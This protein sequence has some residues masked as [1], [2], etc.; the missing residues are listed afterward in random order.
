MLTVPLPL[1]E[2]KPQDQSSHLEEC[3]YKVDYQQSS[4]E[5]ILFYSGPKQ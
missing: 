4:N 3:L 5:Y 2:C 1:L